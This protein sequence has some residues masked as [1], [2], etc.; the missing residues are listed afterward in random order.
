MPGPP[1]VA[2]T[3]LSH[4]SA[5][6]QY[7][8][9]ITPSLTSPH[10][11]LRHPSPQITIVDAQSLQSID[12]LK[13]GHTGDVTSIV[14]DGDGVWSSGKDASVVRWDER[15]RRAGMSIKGPFGSVKSFKGES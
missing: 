5:D 12:S 9:G 6:K 11:L 4:S 10:L 14:S 7:I 1:P 15:G 2:H 8:L 13:G 3:M